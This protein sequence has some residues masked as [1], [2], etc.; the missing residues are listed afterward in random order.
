MFEMTANNRGE[1]GKHD[2]GNPN[3]GKIMEVLSQN[4][5]NY[6]AVL[7]G[8]S[9]EIRTQMN[10]IVS[11]AFLLNKNEYREGE[12]DEFCNQIYDASEMIITLF[13]NF[14]DSTIIDTGNSKS[15]SGNFI[16]DRTFNGLFSEFREVLRKEKYKDLILVVECQSFNSEEYLVDANRVTRVIRNLF[17]NA[18]SNTK[19]G[20][21]KIGYFFMDNR[22]T[23]YILDSGEGFDKCRE[24][25]QSQDLTDSLTRFNDIY[26][27]INLTLTRKLIQMMN[28]SFWIENNGLTGSGLYLS[29]PVTPI[30][31]VDSNSNR[32]TNSMITI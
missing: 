25:L 27:A 26:S 8:L 10:A 29:I 6:P 18:L 19:T 16:P 22:L 11:F 23:F 5:N 1:S 2:S 28:G 21:I 7:A 12:K 15:E 14:L 4:L 31:K 24:F 20:Y 3:G 32:L 9:R 13:D 30:V 17:Q